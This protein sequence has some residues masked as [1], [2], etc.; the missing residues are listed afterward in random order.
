M[1]VFEVYITGTQRQPLLCSRKLDQSG[2]PIEHFEVHGSFSALAKYI[3][4]DQADAHLPDESI[5][6]RFL[7]TCDVY[8]RKSGV[9][10]LVRPLTEAEEEHFRDA[11]RT[12]FRQE[13]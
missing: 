7:P 3:T 12:E 11:L 2:K 10:D 9:L 5:G 8:I 13:R 1:R 4:A 6:I